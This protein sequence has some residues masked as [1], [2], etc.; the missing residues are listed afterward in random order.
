M[1][2]VYVYSLRRLTLPIVDDVSNGL[3]SDLYRRSKIDCEF[4]QLSLNEKHFLR[5]LIIVDIIDKPVHH[6]TYKKKK[7]QLV[8]D[9]LKHVFSWVYR[10]SLTPFKCHPRHETPSSELSFNENKVELCVDDPFIHLHL[11]YFLTFT[12]LKGRKHL[13]MSFNYHKNFFVKIFTVRRSVHLLCCLKQ[14]TSE[15]STVLF[16]NSISVSASSFRKIRR[17]LLNISY[18]IDVSVIKVIQM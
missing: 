18:R 7:T 11:P 16:Q 8:A 17:T 12:K 6:F 2:I 15:S 1:R 9:R 3:E 5:A 4:W 10:S 13:S 14:M